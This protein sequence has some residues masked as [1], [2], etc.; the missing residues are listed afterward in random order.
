[1]IAG[2]PLIESREDSATKNDCVI[3]SSAE[4]LTTLQILP[5]DFNNLCSLR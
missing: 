5:T 3:L 1:M 4:N 2:V